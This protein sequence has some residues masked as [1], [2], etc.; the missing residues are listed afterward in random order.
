VA[1]AAARLGPGWIMGRRS[2]G[3]VAIHRAERAGVL[4]AALAAWWIGYQ[5]ANPAFQRAVGFHRVE[6]PALETLLGHWFVWQGPAVLLC[7]AVWLAGAHRGL[8][9]PVVGSLGSGGSWGRTLRAGLSATVVLLALTVGLGAA[10]GGTFGFHP[11]WVKMV[12]DLVSNLYEEVVFRGLVFSA[13]YGAVAGA[14]FPLAGPLDRRGVVVA[15]I[16]SCVVFAWGHGQYP[17]PLRVVLGLVAL[18]F[19]WPWVRARS[20]WAPWIAHT[21][22]D[23][24]GDSILEL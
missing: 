16:G 13:I 6:D 22:G 9:P 17:V 7:V 21:L 4:A 11:P 12:G 5:W 20:L 18:V 1:L 15:A 19:V 10:F 14:T 2:G 24:V 23:V 3:D 8:L